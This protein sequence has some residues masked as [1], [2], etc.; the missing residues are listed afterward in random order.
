MEV[1]ARRAEINRV[2]GLIRNAGSLAAA[3]RS[4]PG[5]SRIVGRGTAYSF[6]V[7]GAHRWLVRTLRHGGLLRFATRDIF[8]GLLGNRPL[9]EL[10][11][12]GELERL[13]IRTP[14]VVA[15]A[16]YRRGLF[17]R[18]EVAREFIEARGDLAG[19][20]FGTPGAPAPDV[21]AA[22]AAAGRLVAQ[23]HR[24]GLFHPD[25]NLRNVLIVPTPPP[26]RFEAW[27]LDLEKCR[28]GPGRSRRLRRRMLVRL[29]HSADRIAESSGRPLPQA[30]WASLQVAYEEVLHE[31]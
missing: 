7:T 13:G 12:A 5:S 1:W 10:R 4:A 18:G 16:V 26:L 24:A 25:L 2:I 20:L 28:L 29:R 3:A 14:P 31:G 27:I 6:P 19:L 21:V 8:C 22:C 17:Y 30:A 9:N 15:V 23:L 11:I